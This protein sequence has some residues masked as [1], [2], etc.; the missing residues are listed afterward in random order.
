MS[1][2]RLSRAAPVSVSQL[3]HRCVSFISQQESVTSIMLVTNCGFISQ[4]LIYILFH[5]VHSYC[6][7]VIISLTLWS[8]RISPIISILLLSPGDTRHQVPGVSRP[9]LTMTDLTLTKYA[10]HVTPLT[11]T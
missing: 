4:I 11:V 2:C 10:S 9:V 5:A 7:P 3:E 1:L 8:S 6:L